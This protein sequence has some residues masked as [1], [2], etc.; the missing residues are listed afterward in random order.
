MFYRKPLTYDYDALEP[1]IDGKTMR[2][3]YTVHYKKYT[4]LLN[5]ALIENNIPQ[6]YNIERVLQEYNSIKKIR[7]NGGGFYNHLLYF[8]SM[9]PNKMGFEIASPQLKSLIIDT[10]GS[11]E[12]FERQ[13]KEA[14]SDVFG[15]G[16]AWLIYDGKLKIATTANQDNPIMAMDCQ[17]LLGM[18]VWEHA[19]YL[20]H[21]AD[22]KAY[23]DDFMKVVCWRSVSDR[24]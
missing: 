14:G 18:D 17:V 5:E 20:K 1:F 15:S 13:F 9:S 22:R 23:M 6:I 4:D 24:L 16:W 10:F 3:H 8:S 19:Y 11:Y 12:S 2:E 21:M 7:N